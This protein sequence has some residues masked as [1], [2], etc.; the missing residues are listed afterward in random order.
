[1]T[2]NEKAAYLKGLCEG[3]EPDATTK[4]GKLIKALVEL[5]SDMADEI[6]VLEEELDTVHAYCEELDEDLGYV[7]ELLVEEEDEDGEDDFDEFDEDE[8]YEVECPAC[9]ET[10]CF[11]CSVDPEELTCPACGGKFACSLEEEELQ[12]LDAE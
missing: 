6:S 8:Y 3:L 4:E 5:V 7:E 2:L 9:G 1:M 12:I 11:D 10:I